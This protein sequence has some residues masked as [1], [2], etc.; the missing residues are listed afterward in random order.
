M[1]ACSPLAQPRLATVAAA[2]SW[3]AGL[4]D[5]W[6]RGSRTRRLRGRGWDRSSLVRF[7]HDSL[8]SFP[9]CLRWLR[10]VGWFSVAR[11]CMLQ[12]QPQRSAVARKRPDTT[13]LLP[14][15]LQ[16]KCRASAKLRAA[17]AA[18]KTVLASRAIRDTLPRMQIFRSAPV[19]LPPWRSVLCRSPSV[20][21]PPAPLATHCLRRARQGPRCGAGR[22]AKVPYTP[23]ETRSPQPASRADAVT[24]KVRPLTVD[25]RQKEWTT[26]D[27]HDVTDRSFTIRRALRLNDALPGDAAPRWSWQPGPWLLVDRTTGHITALHLPDFDAEVSDAVWFRDYAAYCGTAETA[28][29]GLFAIVAQL[30]AR[31]AVVQKQIGK[32]P[33]TAPASARLQARRLAAR[34]HARHPPA[35]RRRRHDLRRR[36]CSLAHRRERLR[37]RCAIAHV[38]PAAN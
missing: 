30:G 36:R 3:C 10:A 5:G 32:W 1:V 14:R 7:P 4:E 19:R 12:R 24:L 16:R 18:R 27:A 23:P 9:D 15:P 21:G 35:H 2:R 33:Q 20:T 34:A 38:W 37:R 8:V 11:Y 29:G 22:G 26:G 13:I 17:A 25:G 31:R 6:R 28:K